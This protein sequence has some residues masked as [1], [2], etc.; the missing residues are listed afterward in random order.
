[1]FTVIGERLPV[2]IAPDASTSRAELVVQAAV[3][4]RVV[5]PVMYKPPPA[6]RA[7]EFEK[8]P[9]PL[10]VM[11]PVADEVVTGALC[12]IAPPVNR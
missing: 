4:P 2:E 9:A 7:P 3:E 12:V 10:N 1:M 5:A 8:A 6:F 11:S